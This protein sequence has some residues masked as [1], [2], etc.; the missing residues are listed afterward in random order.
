MSKN[1]GKKKVRLDVKFFMMLFDITAKMSK[2]KCLAKPTKGIMRILAGLTIKMKKGAHRD[3]LQ[4]IGEEWQR[5]FPSKKPLPI[6]SNDGT[7][8]IAEIHTQCPLRNCGNAM[9]CYHLMEYDRKLV[10]HFG[11]QL[12]VVDSQA[13]KGVDVCK[14]A[15]R[16]KG[17]PVNDLLP[18]HLK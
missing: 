1:N 8:L 17:M 15:M 2:S 5:M 11:G 14:I 10:E 18:A 16:K 13:E 12:V 9:A 4:G 6:I 7:T 3:T